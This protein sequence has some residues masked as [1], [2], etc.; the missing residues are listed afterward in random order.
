LAGAVLDRP[1]ENPFAHEEGSWAVHVVI[2]PGA[3]CLRGHPC[4]RL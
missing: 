1:H 3:W 4:E 2:R